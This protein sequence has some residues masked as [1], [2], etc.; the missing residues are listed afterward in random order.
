MKKIFVITLLSAIIITSLMGCGYIDENP[1][2]QPGEETFYYDRDTYDFSDVELVNKVSTKDKF[3]MMSDFSKNNFGEV[4]FIKESIDILG[5]KTLE[6]KDDYFTYY[7]YKEN[8]IVYSIWQSKNM[9][10]SLFGKISTVEKAEEIAEQFA[11]SLNFEMYNDYDMFSNEFG[12]ENRRYSIML[13]EKIDDKF[14]TGSSISIILNDAGDLEMFNN[15][16]GKS[17]KYIP[18]KASF[19]NENHAIDLAYEY[20]INDYVKEKE[21]AYNKNKNNPDEYFKVCIE[22]RDSHSVN[23]YKFIDNNSDVLW[24]IDI[25]DVRLINDDYTDMFFNIRINAQTG[26]LVELSYKK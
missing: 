7:F 1:I 18:L 8:N 4:I 26:E 16:I 20:I 15:V 6:Y 13:R 9:D 25:S 24:G 23:A 5:D 17:I 10:K 12:G 2:L 11:G 21:E 19:I 3:E 22:E 14:Y